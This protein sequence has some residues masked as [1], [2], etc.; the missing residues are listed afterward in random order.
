MNCGV[1]EYSYDIPT[2]KDGIYAIKE[3]SELVQISNDGELNVSNEEIMNQ[4]SDEDKQ[5]VI[6]IIEESYDFERLFSAQLVVSYTLIKVMKAIIIDIKQI[7]SHPERYTDEYKEYI[8][9]FYI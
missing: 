5:E 2:E 8:E 1:A 3:T 7:Q 4:L 6:R 9:R